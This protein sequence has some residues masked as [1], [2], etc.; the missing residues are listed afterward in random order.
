[1]AFSLGLKGAWVGWPQ[2]PAG[3][4]FGLKRRPGCHLVLIG[5]TVPV[6]DGLKRRPGW[7]LPARA[8]FSRSRMGFA[9]SAW[10]SPVRAGV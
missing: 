10:V 3:L 6:T 9:G 5:S 7:V 1:M 2:A 8:G 4:I